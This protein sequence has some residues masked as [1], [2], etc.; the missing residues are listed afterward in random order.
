MPNENPYQL[1]KK[2]N[3]LADEIVSAKNFRT[4]FM[5]KLK[6]LK[7]DLDSKKIS[8]QQHDAEKA[9]YLRNKDEKYWIDYY[10][11]HLAELLNQLEYANNKVLEE[12][13]GKKAAP[14]NIGIA[15]QPPAGVIAAPPPPV[16][17]AKVVAMG[18]QIK[19]DKKT[20]KRY[21][22]ELNLSREMIDALV[23]RKKERQSTVVEQEYVLYK[24]NDFGKFANQIFEKATVYLTKNYPQAFEKLYQ[25]LSRS[26]VKVLSKTYIS[27]ALLSG[28]IGFFAVTLLAALLLKSDSIIFQIVRGFFI[29]IFGGVGAIGFFYFYPSNVAGEKEKAIKSELPFV[30]VHMSA[31][32]G[33]GARPISMFSTILSSGEYPGIRDEIKKIVNYVNIF[34]YD[35]STA[36][37][38]VSKS[39]PSLKLKDLLDGL[40][41]TIESGGS[42]KEYLVAVADDTMSTYKLERKK[43]T[44]A[45]STYADIYTAVLIAAP[46]LFMVALRII[47]SMGAGIPVVPITLIA[48]FLG[49]PAMNGAFILFVTIMQPK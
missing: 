6:W 29:G 32:A 43:W 39:T 46:L 30:I 47:D 33:S 13:T 25:D 9:K 5:S 3:D 16:K 49:I 1:V 26:G 2:I 17:K 14:P 28:V 42:L 4:R 27:M 35:I 45:V 18:D 36:L 37:K 41:S 34:G 7:Y 48:V 31:V 20:K 10:N 11:N 19:L 23:K 8:K 15:P 44:E 22:Q 21:M 24:G 12:Y 38:V 40:V